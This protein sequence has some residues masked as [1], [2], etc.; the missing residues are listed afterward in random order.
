MARRQ[1]RIEIDNRN[2]SVLSLKCQL[3]ATIPP[4]LNR[5]VLVV[6]NHLARGWADGACYTLV[7]GVAMVNSGVVIAVLVAGGILALVLLTARYDRKRAAARAQ[8]A[9]L[10]GW[11]YSGGGGPGI[12]YTVEGN[13]CAS[14]W[15]VECRFMKKHSGGQTTFFCKGAAVGG[16]I[17]YVCASDMAKMF[18]SAMG[19]TVAGWGWN[20]GGAL[21]LGTGPLQRLM[22]NF[23]EP[24]LGDDGFKARF[25][26][27]STDESTARTALT[28]EKRQ[29]L[30]KYIPDTMKGRITARALWLLWSDEGMVLSLG[31]EIGDPE[32]LASFIEL[33]ITM[34]KE[35]RGG[36][37]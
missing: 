18:R 24:D 22:E 36:G 2:D 20:I 16:G 1:S 26:V 15:R 25:A 11:R 28:E 27:L 35:P 4:N 6:N 32:A 19:R 21:G 10:R 3:L 34:G 29:A 33:G 7:G 9:S 12:K 8:M 31:E 17:A 13:E 30:M 37:W 23:C 14:G 5:T